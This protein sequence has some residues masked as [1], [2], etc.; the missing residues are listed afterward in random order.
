MYTIKL[1]LCWG[2]SFLQGSAQN[3]TDVRSWTRGCELCGLS[4]CGSLSD[5]PLE[6][7][8]TGLTGF[9]TVSV[10]FLFFFVLGCWNFIE[11]WNKEALNLALYGRCS[12]AHF[13]V[14]RGLD[15]LRLDPPPLNYWD[16]SGLHKLSHVICCFTI[17]DFDTHTVL[18][19]KTQN[20]YLNLYKFRQSIFDQIH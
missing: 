6:S 9:G 2:N 20:F 18:R 14:L 15:R 4:F 5:H 12:C 11:G 3:N 16:I 13:Y 7:R 17:M 8:V 19:L 1:N 10:I